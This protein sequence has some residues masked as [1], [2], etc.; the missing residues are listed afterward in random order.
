MGKHLVPADF[1]LNFIRLSKID[2]ILADYKVGVHVLVFPP[3]YPGAS[4]HV[5]FT[6]VFTSRER[7][8]QNYVPSLL[9]CHHF[10]SSG[11][12]RSDFKGGAC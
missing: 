3:V 10:D 1:L 9:D 2:K 6:L 12:D 5:R 4:N 11:G 7:D 8:T